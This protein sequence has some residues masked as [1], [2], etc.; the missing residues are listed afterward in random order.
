MIS[1]H[2]RL[3]LD[4]RVFENPRY[5]F[6]SVAMLSKKFLPIDDYC[7][8]LSLSSSMP[9]ATQWSVSHSRSVVKY[10]YY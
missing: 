7:N 1:D 3:R 10:Y 5:S 9:A 2:A 6:G 4:L 8:H